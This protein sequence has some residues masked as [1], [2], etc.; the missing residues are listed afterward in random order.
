MSAT[1][2]NIAAEKPP[3]SAEQGI[4]SA[5]RL[6]LP[7]RMYEVVE[8][9]PLDIETEPEV[10]N[11]EGKRGVV[12]DIG[13]N[14]STSH[15]DVYVTLQNGEDWY[16]EDRELKSTGLFLDKQTVTDET[17]ETHTIRV[18]VSPTTNE[19]T[20]VLGDVSQMGRKPKPLAIDLE[21][22]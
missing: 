12:S 13:Y 19:G 20:V 3:E 22:L 8:I 16:F 15:W 4:P 1:D 11:F 7:F 14:A 9:H 18:R 5:D 6:L 10:V 2:V 21:K 17:R